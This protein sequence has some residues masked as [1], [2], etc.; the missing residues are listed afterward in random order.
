MLGATDE[1][2]TILGGLE[3]LAETCDDSAQTHIEQAYENVAFY[4]EKPFS[5]LPDGLRNALED[6]EFE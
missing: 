6:E 5:L 3:T 1:L 2:Q 4:A